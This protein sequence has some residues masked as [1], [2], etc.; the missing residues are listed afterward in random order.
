MPQPDG[1]K[2]EAGAASQLSKAIRINYLQIKR[3]VV[4]CKALAAQCFAIE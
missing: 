1:G 2:F 3:V 4:A